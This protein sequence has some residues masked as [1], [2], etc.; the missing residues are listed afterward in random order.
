MWI[1]LTKQLPDQSGWILVSTN[2]GVG[3]AFYNKGL[4]EIQTLSLASNRQSTATKILHWAEMPEAP[5]GD[6][7]PAAGGFQKKVL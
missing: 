2:L 7:D 5:S 4:N 1:S 3:I 6:F